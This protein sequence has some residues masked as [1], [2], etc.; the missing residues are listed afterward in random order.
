MLLKAQNIKLTPDT[1]KYSYCEIV[2]HNR[3][4]TSVEIDFGLEMSE[5]EKKPYIDRSTGELISFKSKIDA[6]NFMSRNG[7]ELV[8]VSN[9]ITLVSPSFHYLLRK[10][11]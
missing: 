5:S 1:I 3:N 10:R 6:L 7:W 8:D 2:E 9:I 11:L 4:K